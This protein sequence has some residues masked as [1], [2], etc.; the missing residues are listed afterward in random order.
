MTE[1]TTASGPKLELVPARQGPLKVWE[2]PVPGTHYCVGVDSSQGVRGGDY[3]VVKVLRSDTLEEVAMWKGYIDPRELGRK[4]AWIGWMYNTAFIVPEANKDGQSVIWELK[5]M[6]Y[7]NVY[8]TTTYDRIAGERVINKTIGFTTTLKTRP[9]LWNHMRLVVNHGWGRINSAS[10]IEEMKS[11]RYDEKG[12][13][14]HPRNGHDD[15]TVGWGLA[16]VG[17]DQAFSRGEIEPEAKEPT[18]YE[19]RHWAA[20]QDEVDAASNPL[21]G[22]MDVE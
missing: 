19:E 20:F 1:L 8:R 16:L 22:V 18:T 21:N 5:E 2:W 12:I 6:A 13:P 7:P 4:A 9:W 11:I 17:R 15:E 3:S 10:Q 14:V